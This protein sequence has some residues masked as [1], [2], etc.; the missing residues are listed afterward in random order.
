MDYIKKELVR[1]NKYYCEIAGTSLEDKPESGMITG[2][3]FIE[4]DTA[5]VYSWNATTETWYLICELGGGS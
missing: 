2:S 4:Q 3:W 5:K 1:E